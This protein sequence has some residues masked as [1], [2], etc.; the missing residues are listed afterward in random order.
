MPELKFEPIQHPGLIV[1]REDLDAAREKTRSVAWAKNALDALCK[2]ADGFVEEDLT[3]PD[4]KGQWWHYYSCEKDQELAY[5]AIHAEFGLVDQLRRGILDDGFWFECSWGYHFYTMRAVWPLTEAARNVGVDVYDDRFKSFF[6]IPLDFAFPGMY[7]PPLN[8]SGQRS[9]VQ[10]QAE[11]YELAYARWHDPRHAGL[12][13]GMD[14]SSRQALCFGEA[15]LDAAAPENRTSVNFSS[16]GVAVLRDGSDD[17]TLVTLDY[18]P[19]GGG[20]GHPDKLGIILYGIG[21]ELAPD[22]GSI[23]YSVP[24]HQEW[25][26]T[27]VSHN[28]VLVDKQPQEA[29][30]GKLHVFDIRDDIRI[31]SAS[32]HDAYPG[33][34]FNRTV[35]LLNEGIVLDLCELKSETEH[36]YDWVFHCR[37]DFSSDLMFDAM[38]K[39]MG[40]T[41]GYQHVYNPESVATDDTWA[42]QWKVGE[43]TVSLVQCGVSGTEVFGGIGPINPPPAKIP[44]V[45]ARRRGRS[46]VYASALVVRK[47]EI[48]DLDLSVDLNNQSAIFHLTIDGN[49]QQVDLPRL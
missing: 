29:C 9:N 11:F 17:L 40:D 13:A 19:H 46:A 18:G 49:T 45:I 28:T 27:T 2:K 16:S 1:N 48:S 44:M 23:S 41:H 12:L 25:F 47:D 37:G 36:A 22:P 31:A 26:K 5:D 10:K 43:G 14:R 30:M 42:A 3:V 35:A 15:E 34:L 39:P 33:V 24:L 8:D 7:V 21:Q 4:R 32:A 20:H 6:D 38:G